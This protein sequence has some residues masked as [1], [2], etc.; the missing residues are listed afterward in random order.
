MVTVEP[1][2]A[3]PDNTGGSCVVV[4]PFAWEVRE[5]CPGAVVGVG[6]GDGPVVGIAVGL[7]FS[8]AS[9]GVGVIVPACVVGVGEGWDPPDETVIFAGVVP[10]NAFV[11]PSP[12]LPAKDSGP[13]FTLTGVSLDWR[14][15]NRTVA[16]VPMP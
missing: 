10:I 5:S 6:E 15:L 1:A 11:D 2:G 4:V 8:S 7:G 16:T 3:V 14:T 12:I 13:K 9:V